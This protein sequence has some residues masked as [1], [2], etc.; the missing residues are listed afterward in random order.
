MARSAW[1]QDLFLVAS[2]LNK[3]CFLKIVVESGLF[4]YGLRGGC[5]R[6]LFRKRSRKH[7]KRSKQYLLSPEKTQFWRKQYLINPEATRKRSWIQGKC[8][9]LIQ[10]LFVISSR[11]FRSKQALFSAH[12]ALIQDLFPIYSGLNKYCFMLVQGWTGPVFSR[13]Q[14]STWMTLNKR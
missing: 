10:D 14:N 7:W 8:S 13:N 9:A 3:Y 1:I 2:G 6:A 5:A 12:S 4:R 11:W